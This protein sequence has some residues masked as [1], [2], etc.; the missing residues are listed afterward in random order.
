[1]EKLD[2]RFRALEDRIAVM[3]RELDEEKHNGTAL[4]TKLMRKMNTFEW[5][6]ADGSDQQSQDKRPRVLDALARVRR[7]R[8]ATQS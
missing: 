3:R 2:R 4:K 5:L 6:L 8:D 1:M 7:R